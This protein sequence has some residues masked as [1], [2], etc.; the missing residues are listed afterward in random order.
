MGNDSMVIELLI[1][2]KEAMGANLVNTV[3]E[4]VAPYIQSLLENCKIG[5]RILTNLCT[6]RMARSEFKIPVEKLKWKGVSGK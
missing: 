6:E 5:L 3:C 1:D 4:K 2:V